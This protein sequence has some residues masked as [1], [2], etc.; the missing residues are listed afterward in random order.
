MPSL[1]QLVS[2][3][4]GRLNR[5]FDDMFK[6]ELKP[7]VISEISML[8]R[9][10]IDANGI[11]SVYLAAFNVE[12]Q[13]VDFFDEIGVDSGSTILRSVNKIPTPIR[14]KTPVPFVYVGTAGGNKP[15][16][17]TKSYEQSFIKELPYVGNGIT[18]DYINQYIYVYNNIKL[19]N[20]RI[21][22][23]YASF[24]LI[25]NNVTGSNGINYTDD[26]VLPYPDDVIN[27]AISSLMQG[28]LG[29]S[30]SKDKV[31]ATHLD[32]Q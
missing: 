6:E 5:P 23:P 3:V 20:V 19:T 28:V 17:Y 15:F 7:L 30:D 13:A 2:L 11:D 10:S 32:N 18:Y 27:T 29:L 31:T 9:R 14:Y 8:L 12:L 26:M 21:V 25:K 16:G 1:N 24:N 4:A 22:A